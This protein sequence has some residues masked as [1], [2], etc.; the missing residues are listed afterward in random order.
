M[1]KRRQRKSKGPS[2]PKNRSPF[3][4]KKDKLSLPTTDR[5][6][7]YAMLQRGQH[8][9]I[10][11]GVATVLYFFQ[12]TNYSAL[13]R[14]GFKRIN[15]FVSAVF[16]LLTDPAFSI[17]PENAPGLVGRAH[18]FANL[19]AMSAY[20]TTDA[21]LQQVLQQEHNLFKILFLYS[22]K[23]K[24]RL[25]SKQFF[26][27]NPVMASLWFYTYPLPTIGC[28]LPH[29]QSNM[30]EHF[31]NAD[32]RYTPA[33]HRVSTAYFYCT[34]FAGQSRAD[35]KLKEQINKGCQKRLGKLLTGIENKPDRHSLA[36]V[37]SKW[38]PNSAVYKS[39][40][41]LLNTFRDSYKMT[42]I[43]T[44]RDE[45]S[46]LARNYFDEIHTVR[47]ESSGGG[48][49]TLT[50]APIVSND[51]Q[52]VYY[53]DIGMTDESIWL[54]NIRLAPIQVTGYGHP[55]STFGSEIDYFVVGA[56]TE[57]LD[58]LNENYSETPIVL[59]G[60]GCVPVWPTYKRKDPP[61]KSDKLVA[62]CVWGP[63]KYNYTAIRMLQEIS[64]LTNGLEYAIFCSRGVN[65]YNAYLSFE[66]EMRQ[67]LGD[68]A[69]IHHNLEYMDYMEEAEYGD[70]AI[71]SWPFGGYNTV[72]EALYLGKPVITLEGDRFYNRA[73]SALLRRVGLEN[74]IAKS[75]PEFIDLCV[76]MVNDPAFLA[77]QK[78]KL[79]GVDLSK[80]IF[81]DT[82][83]VRYFKRMMELII[84]EQEVLAG[85]KSPLIARKLV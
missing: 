53:P 68:S 19:V 64:R 11:E 36:V 10:C 85:N 26:D 72:V 14:E 1:S 22:V 78:A 6:R 67:L 44:G 38:F 82:D 73:A 61:K 77:E 31:E 4:V 37:T 23:N 12:E 80:A 24:T 17:P 43:H 76:K 55:V 59:P 58:D 52:L 51:F 48:N 39:C 81:F 33:D 79:A 21:T 35:R 30:R 13:D 54:S 15:D 20:D 49:Y 65:R 8:S 69:T 63:D 60:L 75:A 3:E 25:D 29:Y 83:E 18:I 62:N 56:E 2:K 40:F 5:R 47:F 7:L 50:T 34:Y 28:V 42:L 9:Q 74:L 71:N 16:A 45:P 46:E 84:D 32:P 41:P 70:F 66:A 27:M 57:V